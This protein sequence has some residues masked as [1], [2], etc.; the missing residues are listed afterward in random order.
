[1]EL[2]KYLQAYTGIPQSVA[3]APRDV[4]FVDDISSAETRPHIFIIVVDSL[5]RD[6][7]GAYNPHVTFTPHIDAF[8]D[9]GL[10]FTQALSRY[11]ATGLSEPSIWV[12]G[13]LP[14]KQYV[15]PFAPMNALQT[16]LRAQGYEGFISVDPILDK[17]L[18]TEGWVTELDKGRQAGEIELC[19][20]LDELQGKL[21]ARGDGEGPFF[22]YTQPQNIHI[23][24][25]NRGG[26]EP[27]D[28]ADY[29]SFYAP[30]ASRLREVDACFGRFVEHLKRERL[31]DD[32]V[33]ILSSDHGDSLGEEG[34]Y[35]H[36]YTIFPEIVRVPMIIR[37]PD[38]LSDGLGVDTHALAFT[39]DLAPTLYRL[40]GFEP[41]QIAPFF[42]R[43]LLTRRADE[44]H[45]YVAANHLMASSYGPVYGVLTEAGHS[46]Y[47][48]DAVNYRDYLYDLTT[49]S[50]TTSS[51]LDEATRRSSRA[52]IRGLVEQLNDWYGVGE[53]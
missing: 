20:S 3:L 32:S 50:N 9:D 17:I 41:D 35:G 7:V 19:R 29:G 10:V 26:I 16:L 30:Y 52:K 25:I 21:S 31:Y 2:F 40:L 47:I 27:I 4:R 49:D 5:R 24:T 18:D 34:R 28:D 13:L 22:A 36:A 37:V 46:L 44:R 45:D 43:P 51:H 6:Y 1:M 12:G 23:A 39:T 48:L 53:L 42:G 8:A 15:S 38:A 33:I 14:H 11:G